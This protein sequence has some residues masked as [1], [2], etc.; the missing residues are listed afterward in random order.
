MAK[1]VGRVLEK[2]KAVRKVLGDDRKT[3]HLIPTWQDIHVD[4]L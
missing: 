1:L 4:E 2:K 3:S